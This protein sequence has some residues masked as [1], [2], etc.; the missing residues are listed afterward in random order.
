MCELGA[1]NMDMALVGGQPAGHQPVGDVAR[2][3]LA[4]SG[5]S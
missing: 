2:S 1:Y 3:I 4:P 5:S